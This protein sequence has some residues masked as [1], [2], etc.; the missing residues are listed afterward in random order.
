[1]KYSVNIWGSKPGTNDDCWAGLDFDSFE[2]ALAVFNAPVEEHFHRQDAISTA[3]VEL[4]SPSV[5]KQRKNPDFTPSDDDG[6]WLAEIQ[7]EH[8]MLH[9]SLDA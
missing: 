2:E 6:E 8:L 3:Y 5:H 1:M 4:D 7:R 9:G